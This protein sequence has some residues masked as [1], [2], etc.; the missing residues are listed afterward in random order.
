AKLVAREASDPR[1]VDRGIVAEY[2]DPIAVE[3]IRAIR[4]ALPGIS[5]KTA[6]WSYLFAVGALVMSVLDNRIERICGSTLNA[7]DLDTKTEHLVAFIKAGIL[8]G[9][10]RT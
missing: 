7:M 5:S 2:F 4:E 10:D 6:H 1:E 3:F 9:I 8:A